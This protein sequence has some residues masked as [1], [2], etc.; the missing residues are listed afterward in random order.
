[1]AQSC[2]KQQKRFIRLLQKKDKMMADVI[3]DANAFL[4]KAGEK[5]DMK[6]LAE[7]FLAKRRG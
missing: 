4:A 2:L 7:E 1:M 3:I 5:V 6:E